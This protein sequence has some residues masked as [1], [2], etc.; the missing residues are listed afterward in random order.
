M[1]DDLRALGFANKIAVSG[2][3]LYV[4]ELEKNISKISARR[5]KRHRVFQ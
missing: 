5:K 1:R 4:K 2:A 3:G